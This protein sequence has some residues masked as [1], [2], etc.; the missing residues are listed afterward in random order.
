[1]SNFLPHNKLN[2]DNNGSMSEFLSHNKLTHEIEWPIDMRKIYA[3]QK[4]SVC[5]SRSD[6]FDTH[7]C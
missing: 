4:Q 1:M 5:F 2:Q 3:L 7:Y 6:F